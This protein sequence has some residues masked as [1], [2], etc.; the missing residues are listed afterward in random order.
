MEVQTHFNKNRNVVKPYLEENI[1]DAWSDVGNLPVILLM[2][3][4]IHTLHGCR[5]NCQQGEKEALSQR[6]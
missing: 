2:L 5:Q 3:I 6:R 4:F 1:V